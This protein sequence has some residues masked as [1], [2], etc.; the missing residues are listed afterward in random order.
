MALVA[1]LALAAAPGAGAQEQPD[2]QGKLTFTVGIANDIDS[3]NPFLGYLAESYEVWQTM[4]DY[5]TGYSQ[6]DYSPTPSLA[7]SWTTSPD[8]KT[9]TYKIRQGVKWSDGKP[10]TA[11]DVAY[12][13][14]RV[15]EGETEQTNY[16]GYVANIT[17]VTAPDDAT[18]V[19]TTKVPTPIMT[20]LAVPILPEHIWKNVS[21]AE[22]GS[23]DNEKNVVGSGPFV[24]EQ[25]KTGQFVRLRANKSYW[26]GAPKI[27]ELVFR[28][29]NNKDA[30]IQALRKGEVDFADDVDANLFEALKNT[31]G[32]A[33][34]AADYAGFN[35]L[36]FNTGAALDTG[37]PIGDGHPALKDKRVRQAIARAVDKTTLVQRVLRGYGSEA[38]SVIPAL[39]PNLQW[40]PGDG[41]A[42]G[43]DLA[44]ANQLLDDAGYRDGNGD[45][46]REMPNGD[47]PLQ[48]RLFAR[49]ESPNSQQS[50]KFIEGWLKQIGI[51]AKTS[52]IEENRLTEVIGQ[53]EF[54]MFEWGWVVEPD[55][56]YQLS[57]FTCAQRSYKQGAA[58]KITPGLSDSFYC[59]P[60]YDKLYEQQG[61]TVDPNRRA[62]IVKQMQAI[63]YQDAP[64]VVTFYYDD[65]QAY[66]SDRFGGF[67]A[68]PDPGGVL[69]F[70][71]G[72]Y[73][74]QRI[75]PPEAAAAAGDGDGGSS[76]P[77]V[78]IGAVVV[79]AALG[80]GLLLAR[81]RSSTRDERE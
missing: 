28:V 45:G 53:G 25:R 32:I 78:L 47:R 21:D 55:P 43:F 51:A 16:G 10:L 67:V 44:A 38:T 79:L 52:V 72:T 71:Y 37:E 46:V 6:K 39:Y 22:I 63:L 23:F 56:D 60:A 70:Q 14:N 65:L 30:M 81:R 77:V 50:V 62:E 2:G 7:E 48:F 33:T 58:G 12:T 26:G 69:L 29:F 1:L 11:K 41:E 9:W 57:V 20:H 80:G 4:Y 27:D 31:E 59:N 61:Q 8:G 19:M 24:F 68:Q 17:S 35:E 18:V 40:K 3:M 49:Q 36:A 66:R 73:S 5:L 75:G 15:L 74:Y 42:L 54:D 64:Y 76:L 13:F 34:V